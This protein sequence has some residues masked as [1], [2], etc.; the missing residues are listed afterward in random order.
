MAGNRLSQGDRATIKDYQ[1]ILS[2][3]DVVQWMLTRYSFG[4]KLLGTFTAVLSPAPL[5]LRRTID[6]RRTLGRFE[7]RRPFPGPQFELRAA[8]RRHSVR[9]LRRVYARLHRQVAHRLPGSLPTLCSARRAE[10]WPRRYRRAI[11][12]GF[13]E[14]HFSWQ[15]GS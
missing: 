1:Q 8:L 2:Q 4:R 14:N 13:L 7:R 11:L 9:L 6:A 3:A 12:H 10:D 5:D 15:R